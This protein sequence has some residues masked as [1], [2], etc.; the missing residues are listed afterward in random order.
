MLTD[1]KTWV[2]YY[3]QETNA[4]VSNGSLCQS[5]SEKGMNVKINDQKNTYLLLNNTGIFH[6][7]FFLQNS[8]SNIPPTHFGILQQ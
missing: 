5:P 4:K 3:N 7:E 6:Y 2:F 8:Q 1:D